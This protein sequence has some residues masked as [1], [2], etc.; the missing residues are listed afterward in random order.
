MAMNAQ[1]YVAKVRNLPPVSETALKLANLLH[2]PAISN[3]DVVQ[4]LKRDNVLTAKMLRA[5]NSS[6]F[7]L[8]EP[9]YSVDQAVLILGHQQTLH[10]VLTLAFGGALVV[11]MPAYAADT[12][13]LWSHSIASAGA[14]EIIAQEETGVETDVTIAFTVGLLH[15]IG[16]LVLD[17]ALN[18]EVYAQIQERIAGG[19]TRARAERAILA[20]DHAEV[21]AALLRSW[22][23]PN[24]IVEAVGNHHRPTIHPRPELSA[25]AYLANWMAHAADAS[26]AAGGH[27][28]ALD[29]SVSNALGLGKARLEE[30]VASV[31][32]SGSEI[33]ALVAGD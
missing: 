20:T 17:Q 3:D 5:C 24:V 29:A 30:L 12:T 21:G 13:E 14:A 19:E 6:Y 10:I 27:G 2:E 25:I 7:G 18:A 22:R 11:P 4:L 26:H 15:D 23:L 31:R 1:E 16:K 8:D 28:S 33:E 32:E 9:V